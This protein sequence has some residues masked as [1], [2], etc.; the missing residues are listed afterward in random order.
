MSDL[1]EMFADLRSCCLHDPQW[2][3]EDVDE[4]LAW[5]GDRQT[6]PEST[7]IVIVRLKTRSTRLPYLFEYGLLTESEDYTGH[8]CQCDSMTVKEDGLAKLLA[9]LDD[10]E[11]TRVIARKAGQ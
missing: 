6:G 1:S 7:A 8:G 10:W 9:H 3:P 5:I 4:E 2:L 11:L